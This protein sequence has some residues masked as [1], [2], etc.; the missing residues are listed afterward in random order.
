[1]FCSLP[2]RGIKWFVCGLRTDFSIIRMVR[3]D[4]SPGRF[5]RMVCPDGGKP[6]GLFLAHLT[7]NHYLC[8]TKNGSVVQLDRIADSGSVGWGF[9]SL[10]S[11]KKTL[12]GPGR[13]FLFNERL[14]PKFGF[15]KHFRSTAFDYISEIRTISQFVH[16]VFSFRSLWLPAENTYHPE[17]LT[18]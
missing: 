14:Q 18:H 2:Q 6:A 9:E 15:R 12:P 13:V 17:D 16:A 8:T 1:M 4:G 11:H 10:R 5:T 7:K 3:P